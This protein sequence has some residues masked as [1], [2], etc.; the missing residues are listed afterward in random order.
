MAPGPRGNLPRGVRVGGDLRG[1]DL[2][3][4]PVGGGYQTVDQLASPRQLSSHRARRTPPPAHRRPGRTLYGYVAREALRPSLFALVGLSTVVLSKELVE[5]SELWINRGVGLAEVARIALLQGVPVAETM[6]PFAVLVGALVALGRLGADRE[7]LTLEASGVAAA[8]L[9][10]PVAAFAGAM[11]AFSLVLS[12]A[13]AP[14]ANRALDRALERIAREQPW[15]QFRPGVVNEFGG[16]HVEAREVSPR[17]DVLRG[18]LLWMPDVGETIFAQQGRV[19]GENGSVRIQL[20]NGSV[21]LSAR[22]GANEL[23]FREMTTELPQSDEAVARDESVRLE[24][25][26]LAELAQRARDF[27][28]TEGD[29][30]PHAA[31]ELHRRAATP[32]ATLLF[33]FLAVPLFLTRTQFSRSS[34]GV[35]GLAATVAYFA[36]VQFG[37]GLIQ[38]GIVGAAIGVWIPNVVLAVLSVT[39]LLRLRSEGVL[40][41]R[42]ANPKARETR[43][44]DEVRGREWRPRRYALPRYVAGRFVQLALLAFGVLFVAYLLIDVMERLSWFARYRATGF[45]ILRFYGARVPLL[46]SRVVPMALLVAMSL[47]VSL[48]AVEGELIGMRACGIPAPRAMLPALVISLFVVPAYFLL[49]NVVLPR[50]NALADELKKTEIK[51]TYYRELEEDRKAAVWY[52]SGSMVLEAARFDTD[53]GVAR[54]LTIYEIGEGGLPVSRTDAQSARHIGRGVWRLDGSERIEA[55]DGH[56]RRVPA[57]RFAEL[58]EALPAEVDTMHL[59]IWDLAREIQDVE[60][61]GYDATPLRVDFH[62]KMADA[63][64]CLV[65]PAVVLFFAVGGPPFPGPAQ[66]L[67]ASGILGVGW[68]LLL[69]VGASLARGGFVPA[70]VGGW[71]ATALFASL[72][73]FFGFRLWRR[74]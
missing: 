55:E 24:G 27:T 48:L 36:L 73:V 64:S 17:G 47:T 39:L 38:G 67:L 61:S 41:H 3:F 50:T 12:F 62:V 7:I 65:L 57:P 16:W 74:L 44:L 42:F 18:V 49:N 35:L 5:L 53:R 13:A 1:S 54:K 15:A 28:P 34:G 66:T 2:A 60:K 70:W 10:A 11:T 22:G 31:V 33:G 26:P 4:R 51:E 9:V 56:V 58:G 8:R 32:A 69:G 19:E 21:F 23:R 43:P 68:I 45:E 14:A 40:G 71:G 25:L 52:R 20:E 37:E 59:S 29:D 63:L 6:L 30:F 72:A 46:V